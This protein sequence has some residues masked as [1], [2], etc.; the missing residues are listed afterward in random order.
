MVNL[1]Y[2]WDWAAAE[3]EFKRAIALKPTD[4]TA[5]LRYGAALAWFQRFD[6]A[7]RVV[8]RGLEADPVDPLLNTAMAQIF[9][10]AR[11]YDEAIDQYRKAMELDPNYFQTYLM[12]GQVHLKT[13]AYDEAIGELEKA[14]ELGGGSQVIATLA[15]AYALSGQT[16]E[17]RKTL[18]GLTDRS[19]QTYAPPFDVALAYVGLGDYDQAFAWLEKAYDERARAMLSLKVNPLL[20]PLRSDPRFGALI[21]RMR[22]LDSSSVVSAK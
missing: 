17:A 4:T 6:E 22:I 19:S 7:H 11:R 12:M 3:R 21:R 14:I 10:W 13:G 16:G 20:D 9:Y 1:Y 2:D 15:D 8:T 18:A 5:Y